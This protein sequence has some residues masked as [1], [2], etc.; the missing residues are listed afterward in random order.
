MTKKRSSTDEVG[1]NK[2]E[3]IRR[4]L[5]ADPTLSTQGIIYN[6]RTNYG[7][8]VTPNY[9]Y[10]TKAKLESIGTKTT[11]VSHAKVPKHFEQL[12]QAESEPVDNRGLLQLTSGGVV[13][14]FRSA[15][16]LLSECGGDLHFATQ[17]LTALGAK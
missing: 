11:R 7:L 4:V 13:A 5:E 17:V 14:I 3:A 9:V 16:R 10:M 12:V 15:T 1:N 2:A 8:E 6:V